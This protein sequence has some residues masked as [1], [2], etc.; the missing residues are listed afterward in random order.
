MKK[1]LSIL[2][3]L[4][5]CSSSIYG[6]Q[7]LWEKKFG[8]VRNDEL[9]DGI[10]TSDYSVIAIGR[11]RNFGTVVGSTSKLG[12]I[13][14]KINIE[15]GDTVWL[16]SLNQLCST[17]HCVLG[18]NN[19]VYVVAPESISPNRLRLTILDTNGNVIFRTTLDSTGEA[20][21]VEKLIRTNDGNFLLTGSRRGLG[22]S[23]TVDMY[24]LKF[25]WLGNVLW[26][27]RFNANP[28]S[29][30]NHVEENPYN[31]YLLSGN[32][33]SRIWRIKVDSVG[34]ELE[35]NFLYQ[36]PSA[37]NFNDKSVVK[38]HPNTSRVLCG[39]L[40]GATSK[41]YFGNNMEV[42]NQRI[43]GGEQIGGIQKPFIHTDG[44]ILQMRASFGYWLNKYNSD[45]SINWAITYTGKF[46]AQNF[47]LNSAIYLPDSSAIF[48]G[49]IGY[50]FTSQAD[51]FYFCRIKN[52]GVPYDPSLIVSNQPKIKGENLVPYPNPT[53]SSLVFKGLKEEGQLYLFNLKGQVVKQMEIKPYQR[54][55]LS[56]LPAGLYPYRVQTKKGH[57]VGRVVRN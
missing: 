9:T 29:G 2:F 13:A 55:Y 27:N 43:W 4:L 56:D 12:L 45:S 47:F 14:V 37:V 16:K 5:D 41:Y 35:N 46:G 28:N 23:L 11:S 20:P 7:I 39:N 24:A 22:T 42:G 49:K 51:D 48:V 26:N 32:A 40:F 25:D 1:I 8:W 38:Q 3:L 15:T 6:Q 36:S 53:E 10:Q 18:N 57:H 17:P 33:G 21:T 34:N 19:L 44:T 50:A 30:G 54:I 52:V 31:E